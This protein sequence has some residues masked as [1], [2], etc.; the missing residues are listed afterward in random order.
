MTTSMQLGTR[1]VRRL[2]FGAMRVMGATGADGRP[3]REAVIALIRR[4]VE[5]GVQVIDTADVY[6]NGESERMIAEALHPYDPSVLIAT[7]G[8]FVPGEYLPNG[9][10]PIDAR[11]ERLRQVC[12]ESLRR[13]KVERID[14]YQLHVPD[15]AVPF[16]DVIGAL[17]ELRE[18]GKI[19]Q[20]GLCNVGRGQLLAARAI[21]PIASLQNRYHLSD[22]M[23]DKVLDICAA[24]GI[25]FLPWGP[26]S[27]DS[28]AL[29]SVAE[30][31]GAT[32]QQ[33]SLAWSLQRSPA[34]LPIPGT[35]SIAHLEENMAAAQLTLTAAQLALLENEETPA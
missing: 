10:L 14:L 18:A 1:T 27:S 34:M 29:A 21:T 33:V 6:G 3:N 16:E 20:I 11:P 15:P 32:P 28:P 35:S 19:D 7:K 9:L 22:R 24:E 25:V 8:G 17:A 13:L 31:L 2:G 26:L 12:D 4:A 23:S 5:L 30:Q